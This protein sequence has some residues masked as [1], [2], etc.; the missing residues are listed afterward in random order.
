MTWAV[1]SLPSTP[2]CLRGPGPRGLGELAHPLLGEPGMMRIDPRG[3]RAAEF[4]QRTGRIAQVAAAFTQVIPADRLGEWRMGGGQESLPAGA[5]LLVLADGHPGQPHS[6][7][8]VQLRGRIQR[9]LV[10]SVQD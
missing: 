8:A 1:D 4:L 7:E 2:T 6:L 10:E 9:L 5:G 3:H